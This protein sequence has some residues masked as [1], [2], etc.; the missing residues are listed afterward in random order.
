MFKERKHLYFKPL[1]MAEMSM[2]RIGVNDLKTKAFSKLISKI[3]IIENI[4]WISK[5]GFFER[6]L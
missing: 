1:G 2:L 4:N 6:L 3:I 5:L